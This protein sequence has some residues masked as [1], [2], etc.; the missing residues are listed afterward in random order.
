M[1]EAHQ[2]GARVIYD[3]VTR[4]P[5]VNKYG[6]SASPW[7]DDGADLMIEAATGPV[8][9][10][11][12]PRR[13]VEE[14]FLM[15]PEIHVIDTSP[16]WTSA[17][18]GSVCAMCGKQ[19]LKWTR[20]CDCGCRSFR[21]QF[22]DAYRVEIVENPFRNQNIAQ[23]VQLL[24]RPTMVLV[25]QVKHGRHLAA[26]IPNS[27]FLS[28]KMRGINRQKIFDKVRTG[29]QQVIICTTIAD[30][31]MDLPNLEALVLA[32]GGKSSTRHLQRIG[33]VVRVAPGKATPIVIDFDDTHIHSWFEKHARAR[34][35]IEHEE[36]GD[37]VTWHKG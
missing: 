29:E 35:K 22:T 32:G 11:V 27:I 30:M 10:R 21:S 7:R 26:L 17:A 20:E 25:K 8:I 13:L 37:L 9:F 1:D 16:W 2:L 14:G 15:A 12:P 19:W 34:R 23:H 4:I 28:G 18:W 33:R 36:W 24:N 3:T 6:F 5:A 31:G